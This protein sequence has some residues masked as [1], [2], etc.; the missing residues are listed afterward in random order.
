MNFGHQFDKSR[1]TATNWLKHKS[2]VDAENLPKSTITHEF[3][4]YLGLNALTRSA[5]PELSN[6]FT[7]LRSIRADYKLELMRSTTEAAKDA[8][9]LGQYANTNIDEFMAE[10]FT[11]YKLR[12][13]PSK[14]A[15]LVGKLIDKY[16][17]K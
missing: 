3:A 1:S 11:E 15:T 8:I 6:F 2:T 17:L 9:S 14:Y 12:S 10:A 5:L 7:E 16:F 4:H 13:N